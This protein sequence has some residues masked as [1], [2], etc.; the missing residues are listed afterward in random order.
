MQKR[1]KVSIKASPA[2]DKLQLALILVCTSRISGML[3]NMVLI[4]SCAR[5]GPPS[6]PSFSNGT[7]NNWWSRQKKLTPSQPPHIVLEIVMKATVF[8][9]QI[10]LSCSQTLEILPFSK[11]GLQWSHFKIQTQSLIHHYS[12]TLFHLPFSSHTS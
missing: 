8:S 10:I 7:W 11:S 6:C 4:S 5:I 2:G 3:P 1:F 9:F 12:I